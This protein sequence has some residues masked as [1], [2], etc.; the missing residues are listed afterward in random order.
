MSLI[1]YDERA[2]IAPPAE[3]AV[4]G[5]VMRRGSNFKEAND[6]SIALKSWTYSSD[7]WLGMWSGC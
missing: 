2:M 5:R 6:E 1:E 7:C 4:T 3:V